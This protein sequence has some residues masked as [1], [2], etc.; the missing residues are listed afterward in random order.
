[1]YEV[2]EGFYVIA[3]VDTEEIMRGR[4]MATFLGVYHCV[5]LRPIDKSK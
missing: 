1:M 5:P 2:N 4:D 3:V